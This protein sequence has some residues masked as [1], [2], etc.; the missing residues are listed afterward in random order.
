[1][2]ST[3]QSRG[4]RKA[5]RDVFQAALAVVAAGGTTAVVDLLITKVNPA[6]SVFLMLFYKVL[7]TYIQNYLETAGKIPVL[8]PSPG[9]ISP[10]NDSAPGEEDETP[11]LAPSA[12]ATVEATV[13]TVGEV[14]GAVT[15]LAGDVVGQVTG[16]VPDQEEV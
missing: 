13:D 11:L 7:I 12:E 1:M 15:D 4:S 8:L 3:A 5:L 10:V 14:T 6:Y 9:L 2:S 16:T